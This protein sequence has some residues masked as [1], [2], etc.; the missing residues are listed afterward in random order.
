METNLKLSSNRHRHIV[1]NKV[2]PR[3]RHCTAILEESLWE[4]KFS[5]ANLKVCSP[6]E[7]GG[8]GLRRARTDK[9]DPRIAPGQFI[10][11]TFKTYSGGDVYNV[12]YTRDLNVL[13]TYFLNSLTIKHLEVG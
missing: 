8:T 5:L 4:R 3:I 12:R 2:Y 9:K 13:T 6:K 10:A 1:K 7:G 11:V